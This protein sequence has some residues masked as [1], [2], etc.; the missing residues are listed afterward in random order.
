[1]KVWNC[2]QKV[3][4]GDLRRVCAAIYQKFESNHS[5]KKKKKNRF[6]NKTKQKYDSRLH[7]ELISFFF[8]VFPIFFLPNSRRVIFTRYLPF[9][10]DKAHLTGEYLTRPHLQRRRARGFIREIQVCK[11]YNIYYSENDGETMGRHAVMMKNNTNF[12]QKS[13]IQKISM[14][15]VLLI[16]TCMGGRDVCLRVYAFLIYFGEKM[17][18]I[19][20]HF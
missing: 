11:V 4:H 9:G 18:K 14:A 16:R 12:F 15:C 10:F 20:L 8:F 2:K 17:R 6:S 1:M 5:K 19:N 7:V 3:G 13:T